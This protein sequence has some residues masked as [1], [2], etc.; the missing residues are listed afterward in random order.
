MRTN[1]YKA[2][3]ELI[4]EGYEEARD[5]EFDIQFRDMFNEYFLTEKGMKIV[6]TEDDI[7]GFIDSF[8]FPDEDEW[9]EDELESQR[10]AF[11]D[12]KYEEYKDRKMGL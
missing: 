11:E 6:I 7:Q 1:T 3:L 5:I 2:N 9:C 4:A 12:A 8:D 10:D